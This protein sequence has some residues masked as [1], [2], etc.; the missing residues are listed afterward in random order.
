ML[1]SLQQALTQNGQ[2]LGMAAN[3]ARVNLPASAASGAAGAQAYNNF[4]TSPDAQTQIPVDD[5]KFY[6]TDDSGLSDSTVNDDNSSIGSKTLKYDFVPAPPLQMS[7]LNEHVINAKYAVRGAIPQR[8]SELQEQMKR[9][10]TSVPFERIIHA[11]IGN[12]QQLEQKPLT[13]Y[14]QVLSLLQYPEL[15]KLA[16]KDELLAR[17]YKKDAV[18]RASRLVKEIGSVG[19][20]S[21][22]QGIYYVRQTVADFIT[23]RDGFKAYPED[24]FLTSGASAAVDYLLSTLCQGEKTGVLIPIPQ[25]PLYTA[26]LALNNSKCLKYYL[27]EET[28]WSTNVEEIERVVVKALDEGVNPA[29]L[30]V[31]NPGNPTGAVL[32]WDSIAKLLEIAAKYGIV[33]IADEVYQSNVFEGVEFHSFK[34]VLRALQK[35]CPGKFDFVQLAS[36]HST[37][38]GVSGECGQRGGYMELVGFPPEVKQVLLKLASISLCPVVTGQALVDLMVAPPEVGDESYEQD[39]HERD[40]IFKE[41]TRRA[42]NLWNMFQSLEGIECQ[43]PQG[44]MYLFPKLNLPAKAIAEAERRGQT[45]CTFY[46]QSLLEAT[47]ICTV[48]GD[49]FGQ[50]A[51]TYHLRTTFLAPGDEW[52][53]AWEKF[54]REFYDKYRD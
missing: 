33:V 31:I 46:C 2:K 6:D 44:A 42:M 35:E 16:E 13:F 53:K 5:T 14:R 11:N 51:G 54:H 21:A 41:L 12:P 3:Y 22:S 20:Y 8:A 52:I 37:S 24:I 48:P 28:G 27:E 23:K 26:T 18:R 32:S 4:S 17:I 30:V 10:P 29:V 15:L 34:K 7:D 47:G 1:T 50:V 45:P 38:K 9:D 25:Y 39:Q 19:A 40:E 43:K 49:G 36:L